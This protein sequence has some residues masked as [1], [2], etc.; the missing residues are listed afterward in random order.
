MG[1]IKQIFLTSKIFRQ[2]RA[3]NKKRLPKLAFFKNSN[4]TIR[5]LIKEKSPLA[6]D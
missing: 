3:Y 5:I 1:I 4:S 6:M 2:D